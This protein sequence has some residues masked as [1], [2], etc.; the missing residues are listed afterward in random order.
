MMSHSPGMPTFVWLTRIC[1]IGLLLVPLSAN[2][3]PDAPEAENPPGP[4]IVTR[5]KPPEIGGARKITLDFVDTSIWDMVKYFADLTGKNF[6]IADQKE[7]SG[8]K[9][10]VISHKPV[11]VGEAWEAFLKNI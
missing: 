9:V 1:L 3:A 4:S 6:I 5:Q 2:A 10:T 8:K 7:L 11:S